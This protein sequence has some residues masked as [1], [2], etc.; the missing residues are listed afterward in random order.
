[1]NQMGNGSSDYLKPSINRV[2]F[3]FLSEHNFI[4]LFGICSYATLVH[5]DVNNNT[6]AMAFWS[7]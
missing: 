6:V 4:E 3:F 2:N 7:P 5:P 1:M